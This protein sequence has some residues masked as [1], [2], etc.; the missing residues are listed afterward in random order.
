MFDFEGTLL[1][2]PNIEDYKKTLS[3]FNKTP[4]DSINNQG[5]SKCQMYALL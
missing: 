5:F 2:G 1:V 4:A 3:I